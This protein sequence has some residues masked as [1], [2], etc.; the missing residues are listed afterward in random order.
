MVHRRIVSELW[1]DHQWFMPLLPRKDALVTSG[2]DQ[3]NLHRAC[4]A[5][6]ISRGLLIP[7]Q[8]LWLKLCSDMPNTDTEVLSTRAF[9][10]DEDG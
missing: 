7:E 8:L 1:K 3:R 6:P 5:S 9:V 10:D 2:Y 4:A